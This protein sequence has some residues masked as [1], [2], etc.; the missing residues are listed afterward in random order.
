MS[1][2]TIDAA[3]ESV[4]ENPNAAIKACTAVIAS[5]PENYEAYIVRAAGN[6]AIEDYSAA[7]QDLN[8]ALRLQ[9]DN[10]K[11]LLEKAAINCLMECYVDAMQDLN[12]SIHLE[13]DNADTYVIR[14]ITHFHLGEYEN[15]LDDFQMA[16]EQDLDAE[17]CVYTYRG[18]IYMR[19]GRM[20]ESFTNFTLALEH[21]S[22]DVEVRKLRSGVACELSEHRIAL[23]DISEVL[24]VEP[25]SRNFLTRAVVKEAIRYAEGADKDRETAGVLQSLSMET[26]INEVVEKLIDKKYDEAI[27]LL[28]EVVELAPGVSEIRYLRGVAKFDSNRKTEAMAD[29]DA[30]I[31]SNRLNLNA[32][33]RRGKA[34]AECNN[35][36]LA[37]K[38]ILRVSRVQLTRAK[39]FTVQGMI[40]LHSKGTEAGAR[41]LAKFAIAA[42][43]LGEI[44]YNLYVLHGIAKGRTGL[45]A[46]ACR[47]FRRAIDLN[48]TAFCHSL[49]S[50]THAAMGNYPAALEA[51]NSALASKE[52]K[53]KLRIT[54]H[55]LRSRVY[56]D[57][58][59]TKDATA[60]RMEAMKLDVN[61]DLP[62][63]D[64][65]SSEGYDKFYDILPADQELLGGNT[66]HVDRLRKEVDVQDLT[67]IIDN[68]DTASVEAY[69]ERGCAYQ[70]VGRYDEAIS[71]LTR[72]IA[73]EPAFWKA[74]YARAR[75]YRSAGQFDKS[76]LDFTMIISNI[77]ELA[78]AYHEL[79]ITYLKKGDLDLDL[80]LGNFA[81][82]IQIQPNFAEAYLGSAIIYD[83]QNEIEK[84]IADC[85]KSID[86][87]E[88]PEKRAFA[89]MFRAELYTKKY[90]ASKETDP[91][92]AKSSLN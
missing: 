15:A 33:V 22:D 2:P 73:C 78:E 42:E 57:L 47:D 77:S 65:D 84:A 7:Q 87:C 43:L 45:Y 64:S 74:Y 59:L 4:L 69:Y 51:A 24:V 79:G 67:L 71:D 56:T 86:L 37:K 90:E 27:E 31:E 34:H 16:S 36:E 80:A 13:P 30:A 46:S 32:I 38:D 6:T 44:P 81:R 63:I 20:V 17:R 40:D 3:R 39:I 92:G 14:G 66:V 91:A 19:Q 60:D 12:R 49:L 52:L 48:E 11:A 1:N 23:H 9:P 54:L 26:V 70:S 85:T 28:D 53:P 5:Y 41:A 68:S 35:P 25:T 55:V 8:T 82:A 72:V 21:D 89:F 76:I 10:A 88:D 58:G 18:K 83:K 50:V 61:S 29:F 75:A 62:V